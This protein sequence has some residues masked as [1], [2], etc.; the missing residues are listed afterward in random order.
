[1]SFD[2]R[3]ISPETY[4]IREVR[5]FVTARNGPSGAYRVD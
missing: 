4:S 5:E 2:I 3:V 1:M